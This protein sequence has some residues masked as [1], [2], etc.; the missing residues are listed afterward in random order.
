MTDAE[1]LLASE[2]SIAKMAATIIMERQIA[3]VMLREIERLSKLLADAK[4]QLLLA[5]NPHPRKP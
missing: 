4:M 2:D 5:E 3:A 1:K